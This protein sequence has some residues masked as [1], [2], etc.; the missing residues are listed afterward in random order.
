MKDSYP[1][2][3]LE[4][5]CR[6]L[7][8]TRQA[9]YQHSWHIEEITIE[10]ELIIQ[11]VMDIR[12]RHPIIGTR[13]LYIMLEPFLEEHKIKAGRDKLFDLLAAYKLLVRRRR[14]RV[15]TTQSYHRF[16]KYPNL[17]R[18]MELSCIHQ[19]WVSDITYYKV[20]G[21]FVYLSFVT[22][23]YSHKIIGYHLAET[24]ETIHSIAALEMAIK[25]IDALTKHTIIHHSDRGVQYCSEAYV[26][27]L[28]DNGIMISMTENGDPLENPVA[29][30]VNGIIKEE[31]LK[32]YQY[33]TIKQIEE[34]LSEVVGFYN[35]ERP[36]MSCSML[37]P[38]S[39]HE[40]N[41]AVQKQWKTYYKSKKS[42]VV[43]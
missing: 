39:V 8:V 13:K 2:I 10:A 25:G 7:G 31:Y 9:L 15:S 42:A 11:Q 12:K 32:R 33:N 23:A 17:I 22:D 14:R 41:L 30:R 40:N 6:L 27:L 21:K 20:M 26:K 37:T 3:S 24:L 1:S 36:H 34:K 38:D 35:K 43:S 28:Q 5:F 19:L 16:H 18:E 4:R 29:E